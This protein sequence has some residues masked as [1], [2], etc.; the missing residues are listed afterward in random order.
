MADLMLGLVKSAVV[1]GTLI[2]TRY[3]I[4]EED[5]EAA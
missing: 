1:E 5:N 4:E 3:A 2:M